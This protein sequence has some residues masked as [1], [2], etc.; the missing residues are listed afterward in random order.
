LHLPAE[1]FE[2]LTIPYLIERLLVDV[3][4]FIILVIPTRGNPTIRRDLGRA[5]DAVTSRV[6]GR[7]TVIIVVTLDVGLRVN[8]GKK[9]WH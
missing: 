1:L 4:A 2:S 3:S 8:V 7:P 6:S 9:G 5:I